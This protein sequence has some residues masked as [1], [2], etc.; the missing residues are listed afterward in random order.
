[1]CCTEFQQDKT[2]CVTLSTRVRQKSEEGLRRENLEIEGR[3]TKY[4]PSLNSFYTNYDLTFT[5]II[6]TSNY[7]PSLQKPPHSP[8]K[9]RVYIT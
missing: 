6:S 4:V 7:I 9:S 3:G 2:M 5:N 1:M 8:L